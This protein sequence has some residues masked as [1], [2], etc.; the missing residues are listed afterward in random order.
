MSSLQTVP[1]ASQV[2]PLF[3]STGTTTSFSTFSTSS[4]HSPARQ[5]VV[6]QR[7][8]GEAARAGAVAG[9]AVGTGAAAGAV[10]RVLG[11]TV[12]VL[13]VDRHLDAILELGA[14][15]VGHAA[16]L[17]MLFATR[18]ARGIGTQAAGVR[19]IVV[20]RIQVGALE[21]GR[22]ARRSGHVQRG[23]FGPAGVLDR[24]AACGDDSL[25]IVAVFGLAE[26]AADSALEVIHQ[27]DAGEA[28]KGTAL[29]VDLAHRE[30]AE[31]REVLVLGHARIAHSA[32]ATTG[33]D[34]RGADRHGQQK[35]NAHS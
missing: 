10:D 29:H 1:L 20:A 3:R 4:P 16:R 6:D 8:T 23:A 35:E 32:A 14:I 28:L 7:L 13:R 27:T 31:G 30:A 25:A 17:G 26:G 21:V 18:G 34:E 33:T 9:A 5:E 2:L 12:D 24:S 22:I 19:A 15:A 11:T